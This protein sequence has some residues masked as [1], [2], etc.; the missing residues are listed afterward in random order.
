MIPSQAYRFTASRFT[1]NQF[2]WLVICLL[3]VSSA[4]AQGGPPPGPLQP[5]PPVPTPPQN[6][7]TAEKALLGKFL[8][9]EEQL[10]S[11]DAVACA[12]CHLPEFGG[13]D[14]RS[15]DMNTT[16]PGFDEVFGNADDVFGSLGLQQQDCDG[17]MLADAM[18]TDARQVTGRR[19]PGFMMAAYSDTLFWD[20]RAGPSF[21][22]PQTGVTVIPVGGALEDQSL[23]PLLSEVE[24]ACV[25][26][27]WQ[28]VI[29]KLE[30]IQPLALAS[31]LPA[32]MT[33]ALVNFP[34]YPDLFQ[35]A[36]GTPDITTQR[37]AFALATYQRTTIANQTPFDDFI[38]QGPSALTPLQNQGRQVFVGNCL[39]CHGGPTLSDDNFHFIGLRPRTEDIG[40]QAVTGNPPD[41]GRFRT[42]SLRNVALRAPY[43]HTGGK[44]TLAEV[45][46][47]YND[48][49]DFPTQAIDP[50]NLSPA[51]QNALV[52][53]LETALT[54]PRAANGLPPFDHP[55][56]QT[57]FRRGDTNED[58]TVSIP[59]VIVLL[60]YLFAGGELDCLDA[61]DADD[62]GGVALADAIVILNRL[63]LGA[64][65]LPAPSDT[66][67][68]P[69]PTADSLGC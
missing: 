28:D 29:D 45:V 16:H 4:F 69:D 23:A 3:T 26:R 38:A 2:T 48:G 36:F 54:D 59:D 61:G 33:A 53:F 37:I 66:T 49:G 57:Y 21:V 9:W 64:A 42:P 20:G 62:S 58:N 60:N 35:N 13:S 15:A 52:N 10:S 24:M 56:L 11:D 17:N 39:P 14:P 31:D 50:L 55:S 19:T 47:F 7:I 6:P 68:G 40:R 43:F 41:Q 44:A 27:T 65:P 25:D 18:F 12:T 22:D 30:V 67:V 32:A 5:L 51:E 8:F 63:F 34:T 46:E 1:I